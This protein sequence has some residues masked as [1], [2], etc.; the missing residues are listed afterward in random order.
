MNTRQHRFPLLLWR[1]LT[2]FCLKDTWSLT[3]TS[4]PVPTLRT[5]CAKGAGSQF[6]PKPLYLRAPGWSWAPENNG[7]TI[8][9]WLCSCSWPRTSSKYAPGSTESFM[10]SYLPACALHPSNY[11]VLNSGSRMLGSLTCSGAFGCFAGPLCIPTLFLLC[12]CFLYSR[13]KSH[14]LLPLF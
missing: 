10:R 4:L 6:P 1:P 12:L 14:Y 2:D 11:S 9:S 13:M 8:L 7:R 3:T 5:L